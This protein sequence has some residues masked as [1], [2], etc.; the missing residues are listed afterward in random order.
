MWQVG[1]IG[2]PCS[3]SLLDAWHGFL[4]RCSSCSWILLS[5]F[6][7][8]WF[9]LLTQLSAASWSN[10]L[11]A[12]L[13][14]RQPSSLATE[15]WGPFLDLHGLGPVLSHGIPVT[16]PPWISSL[17]GN[18][19]CWLSNHCWASLDLKSKSVNNRFMAGTQHS[20]P[21]L[22]P[23][24]FKDSVMETGNASGSRGQ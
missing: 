17:A 11:D 23:G 18:G 20:K 16:Y 22:N 9:T 2:S 4:L 7:Q 10:S 24:L 3:R 15:Y 8:L 21:V 19:Y 14:S 1:S 13:D 12:A 6:M 5:D